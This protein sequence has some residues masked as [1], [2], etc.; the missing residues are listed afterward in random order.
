MPICQPC[1]PTHTPQACDDAAHGRTGTARRCYCQH[2]PRT[3]ARPT[4]QPTPGPECEIPT[5]PRE[6]GPSVGGPRHTGHTPTDGG[7]L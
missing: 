5:D 4:G 2:K 7:T 3:G 1:H 6:S